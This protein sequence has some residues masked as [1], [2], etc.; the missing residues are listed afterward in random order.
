MAV[1]FTSSRLL[2]EQDILRVYV[3][4]TH[5]VFHLLATICKLDFA[6]SNL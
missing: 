4:N 5:T 2:I 1:I 6:V 3:Q